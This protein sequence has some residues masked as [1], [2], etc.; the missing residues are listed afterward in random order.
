MNGAIFG[1]FVKHL[2]SNFYS[3]LNT[4]NKKAYIWLIKSCLVYIQLVL[5]FQAHTHAQTLKLLKSTKKN[6]YMH[7]HP[8]NFA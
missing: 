5:Y 3:F 4:Q 2:Y 6:F 1:F 7:Y 8:K